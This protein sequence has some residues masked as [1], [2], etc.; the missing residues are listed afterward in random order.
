M[1]RFLA[2]P[3]VPANGKRPN[4]KTEYR[5]SGPLRLERADGSIAETPTGWRSDGGS[6]PWW[7][8]LLGPFYLAVAIGGL[9]LGLGYGISGIVGLI[10]ALILLW[11]LTLPDRLIYAYFMHDRACQQEVDYPDK[12]DADQLLDEAMK[13]LK[14][15]AIHRWPIYTYVRMRSQRVQWQQ[16]EFQPIVVGGEV[17]GW[18]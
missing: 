14:I 10:G 1:A 11:F 15:S 12:R 18:E 9:L 3:P 17:V 7:A 16:P 13:A 8:K 4:G 5:A 2:T 6:F